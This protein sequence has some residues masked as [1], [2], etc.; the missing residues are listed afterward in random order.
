ML[1]NKASFIVL[2][3]THKERTKFSPRQITELT[4]FVAVILILLAVF[5]LSLFFAKEYL[6]E[7]ISGA[8]GFLAGG[9]GGYGFA[10]S[11]K[12]DNGNE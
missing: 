11:K 12:S 2:F 9:A 4:M 8:V 6:G 3:F 10:H 7:I 5:V 1:I